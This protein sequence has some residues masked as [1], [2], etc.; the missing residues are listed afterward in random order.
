MPAI[1]IKTITKTGNGAGQ[2]LSSLTQTVKL[3]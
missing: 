3:L 1:T 2:S